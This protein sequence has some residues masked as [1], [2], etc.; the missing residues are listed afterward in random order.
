MLGRFCAGN[1]LCRQFP[2]PAW[3]ALASA[4]GYRAYPEGS[5]L[6]SQGDAI[7][8]DSCVYV[9]L[10]GTVDIFVS[11]G[12]HLGA[13]GGPGSPGDFVTALHR[14]AV[15][16]ESGALGHGGRRTATAIAVAPC[17]CVTLKR[18]VC[19]R[20]CVCAGVC[21]R[22]RNELQG[23][24]RVTWLLTCVCTRTPPTQLRRPGPAGRPQ[25]PVCAHHGP[26]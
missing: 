6:F 21:V 2:R 7:A 8:P 10:E 26:Q 9:L 16:G 17:H 4:L 1:R 14:G 25:F 5:V 24:A 18:C 12:G 15:F 3:P 20:L 19:A 23:A 13:V 22:V 11:D